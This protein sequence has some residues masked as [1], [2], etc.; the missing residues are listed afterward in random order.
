LSFDFVKLIYLVTAKF[1]SDEK[2]GLVS[3]LRRAAVSVPTNIAEGAARQSSKEFRH[4][5]F[6]TAGSLR[7]LDTL[8]MLPKELEF[9]SLN[10]SETLNEKLGIITKCVN[11]LKRSIT[12]D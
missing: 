3:Q 11:G 7:E 5:L 1:P 9:I 12:I 4:F 2:F 6:V 10:D 8:P